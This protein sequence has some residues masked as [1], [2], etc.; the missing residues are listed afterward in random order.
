MI[1]KWLA[2]LSIP[3]VIF[4]AYAFTQEAAP[5]KVAVGDPIV[6]GA[7]LQPYENQWSMSMVKP[8]GTVI[9]DAGNW[10]DE[11]KAVQIDGKVAL[12][13]TQQAT[14]K[15]RK[16]EVAATTKTVNVFDA[17]TMAP[18]SRA[19]EKHLDGGSDSSLSIRFSPD[20][21]RLERVDGG[22]AEVKNLP[23]TM[24]FD[25]YGGIYAVLWAAMPLKQ[26]FSVTY[27]SYGEDEHPEKVSWV[28]ATVTA[29]EALDAGSK[30]RVK[31]WV[32]ESD[33]DI[34]KLKY[35]VSPE[36]PYILRMDYRQQ[37]GTLWVLKMI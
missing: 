13:R 30:G 24:A 26:G 1:N 36:S 7:R 27:P 28:V 16:G 33:T 17:R 18:V 22:K 2:Q 21:L 8:D 31:A 29:S 10:K 23:T 4:C 3:V 20:S 12:Q 11:L 5:L 19:F 15:N 35:W 37:D 14:F 9:A 6:N 34:G 25:F 32:V